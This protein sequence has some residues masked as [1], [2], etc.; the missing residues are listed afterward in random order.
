MPSDV[1]NLVVIVTDGQSNINREETIPEARMLKNEGVT[2]MAVGIG[3]KMHR[4]VITSFNVL[5]M[6]NDNVENVV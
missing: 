4:Y 6:F 3:S 2:I 1:P 5:W